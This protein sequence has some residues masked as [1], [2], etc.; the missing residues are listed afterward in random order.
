M[1]TRREEH[2]LDGVVVVDKPA[3]ITSAGAVELVKRQLGARRAGHAGTLDPI[4]TGVLAVCL[5]DATKLVAFLVADDKA[6][7]VEAVLGV[8]TDTLDRAGQVTRTRD[9]G[10][11]T[12]DALAAAAAA[13]VGE[14][15]QLPPMFSAVKQGGVRLHV[16]AR[17]GQSVDRTPRQ[18]RV[19]RFE[20]VAWTPP[21]ARFAIACSKGTYVRSLIADVGEAVGC[22][23][24]VTELRRT[25]SGA[26]AIDDARPIDALDATCVIPM[27][28]ATRLPIVHVAVGE[29]ARVCA[30]VQLAAE[31][32][33]VPHTGC[34]QLADHDQL[35]AIAHVEAGKVVYDRVFRAQVQRTPDQ[36]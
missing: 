6:Y 7:E 17:A 22:G 12:A 1:A 13:R 3:N 34:F 24:H 10:G 31:R 16:R 14:Q 33:G 32:L 25:R 23:A 9:A 19:D 26:F 4:A 29:V 20:L 28:A 5:D 36:A 11:L 27:L 2:G 30:G 15:D 21:R 35:L 18:V 8:E